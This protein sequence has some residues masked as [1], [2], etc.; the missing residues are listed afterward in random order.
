[1]K[2][3]T[4]IYDPGDGLPPYQLNVGLVLLHPSGL[5][6]SGKR[7]DQQEPGQGWQLPQGGVDVG[8]KPEDAALR[9]LR[10]EVGPTVRAD[11]VAAYPRP[12]NYDF[13]DFT[14]ARRIYDGK[15]R[16]QSQYWFYLRLTGPERAI[17]ISHGWDG[18]APEFSAWA[19]RTSEEILRDIIDVKRPIYGAVLDYLARDVM[20]GGP[21]RAGA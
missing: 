13:K 21:E 4:A 18:E 16:G 14:G 7:R 15:Y 10:E 3:R 8:E 20:P 11:I 2:K 9:E 5:I 1:M 12:L 6:F 19:W 17:D